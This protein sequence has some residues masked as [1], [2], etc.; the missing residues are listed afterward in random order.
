MSI[1]GDSRAVKYFGQKQGLQKVHVYSMKERQGYMVVPFLRGC[2]T[3]GAS[4][5]ASSTKVLFLKSLSNFF[6]P[7]KCGDFDP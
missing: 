7:P 1:F 6:D 5:R 3:L 2:D 4:G